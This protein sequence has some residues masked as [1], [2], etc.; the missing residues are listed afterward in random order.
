MCAFA[1]KKERKRDTALKSES[2][3][4]VHIE[5]FKDMNERECVNEIMG[6]CMRL[7][8][9]QPWRLRHVKQLTPTLCCMLTQPMPGSYSLRAYI[10][11]NPIFEVLF[12]QRLHLPILT[13]HVRISQLS[14]MTLFNNINTKGFYSFSPSFLAPSTST[15]L[16]H[17]HI[18][19][20]CLRFLY[21][22]Y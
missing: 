17:R 8:R 6:N 9:R 20:L 5:L 19:T 22:I 15:T 3:R 7:K 10:N 4:L 18:S 13:G 11:T 21:C 1:R 12:P 16:A 2:G 14:A